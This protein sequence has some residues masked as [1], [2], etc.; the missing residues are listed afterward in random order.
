MMNYKL[1]VES[2]CDICESEEFQTLSNK[3]QFNMTY[4][5]VICKDC[6]LVQINPKP[7]LNE[8]SNLVKND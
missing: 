2:K 3:V 5:V 1:V 6:G 4:R 7:E 8:L